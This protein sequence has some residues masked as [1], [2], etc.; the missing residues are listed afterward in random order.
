MALLNLFDPHTEM[1]FAVFDA[2]GI[3]DMR[4]GEVAALGAKQLAPK[5]PKVLDHIG[6]HGRPIGIFACSI[7]SSILM[8]LGYIRVDLKVERPLLKSCM[9]T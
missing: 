4:T 7:I 9:M 5:N 2:S 8:K 3:T 6:A 1:P